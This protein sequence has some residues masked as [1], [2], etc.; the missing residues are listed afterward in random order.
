MTRSNFTDAMKR[1]DAAGIRSFKVEQ[2]EI[3]FN[4]M[5]HIDD[6]T[7]INIVDEFIR[8]K[9]HPKSLTGWFLNRAREKN[10][11]SKKPSTY[12]CWKD[13]SPED[14]KLFFKIIYKSLQQ[15]GTEYKTWMEWFANR[16]N[17]L[18]GSPNVLTISPLTQF[19][20]KQ[21]GVK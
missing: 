19:L 6:N 5:V 7:F 14:V 12:N 4:Q 21:A 18:D 16:W 15:L 13:Y 17:E 20:R 1:I 11:E 2:I 8:L 3:L 9:Q 10:Y